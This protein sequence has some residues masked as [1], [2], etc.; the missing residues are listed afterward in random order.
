MWEVCGIPHGGP[1]R[2]RAVIIKSFHSQDAAI[3]HCL[4]IDMAGWSDVYVRPEP[5]TKQP[6]VGR[7]TIDFEA[8]IQETFNRI[9]AAA[10]AGERCPMNWPNGP[11]HDLS[12]SALVRRGWIETRTYR[13]NYR[14]AKILVGEHAGK[15]TSD[16]EI[17]GHQ[18]F[19]VNGRY[20]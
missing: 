6:K 7:E 19:R 11:L 10:V 20:V 15:S 14:V 4:K 5:K 2:Q 8:R 17:R 13:R 3:D 12:V 9:V 18:P 1:G 16:E